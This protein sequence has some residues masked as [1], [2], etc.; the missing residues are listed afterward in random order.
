M[1]GAEALVAVGLASNVLQFVDFTT[2]LCIT[3][4]EISSTSSGLPKELD[5]Q[6]SQLS[7]LLGLLRELAEQRK[8]PIFGNDVLRYCQEQAQELD[9]LLK[10]FEGGSNNGRLKNAKL[11]YRSLRQKED[12]AKVGKR[13]VRSCRRKLVF[14]DFPCGRGFLVSLT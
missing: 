4:K 11:A 3:I 14:V 2:K 8:T 10:S 13:H 5:R 7:H 1:S 6:A 12:I 9:L